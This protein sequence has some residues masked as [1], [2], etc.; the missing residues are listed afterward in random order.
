MIPNH[1]DVQDS[2]RYQLPHDGYE[3]YSE[4]CSYSRS[5]ELSHYLHY[6]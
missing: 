1:L 2:Y 6:Q 5:F 4:Y 3:Q